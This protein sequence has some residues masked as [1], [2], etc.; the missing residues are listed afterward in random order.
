MKEE[1][2]ILFFSGLEELP[3]D[4]NDIR[5]EA[6]RDPVL[7]RVPNYTL[8]GWQNCVSNEQLKPYFTRGHEL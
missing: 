2:E 8:T 1:A 7:E 4:A 5:G 3:I 6:R